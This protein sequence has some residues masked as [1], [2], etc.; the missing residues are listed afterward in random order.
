MSNLLTMG[1]NFAF[2][3][4]DVVRGTRRVTRS[5]SDLENHF[6]RNRDELDRLNRQFNSVSDQGIANIQA[7][8]VQLSTYLLN[9]NVAIDNFFEK[10]LNQLKNVEQAK[11][12]LE[13]TLGLPTATGSDLE[14]LQ[15]EFGQFNDIIQDTA[16]RTKFTEVEVTKAFQALVT[17]GYK[18]E[19]A[20]KALQPTLDFTAASQGVLTLEE[21]IN[22]VTLAVT[23]FGNGIEDSTINMDQ[24]LRTS[25]KTKIQIQDMVPMLESMGGAEMSFGEIKGLPKG[26]EL[27]VLAA[28]LKLQGQSA[29]EAGHGV[30]SFGRSIINMFK[31]VN[32]EAFRGDEAAFKRINEKRTALI[33]LM[34]GGH[35]K[36]FDKNATEIQKILNARV[37]GMFTNESGQM[38]SATEILT[39]FTDKFRELGDTKDPKNLALLQTAVGGEEGLKMIRGAIKLQD[40]MAKDGIDR[41]KALMHLARQI[42]DIQGDSAAA[43]KRDLETIGGKMKLLESATQAATKALGE[44]D[45]ATKGLLDVQIGLT[46]TIAQV[47]ANNKTLSK[48]IMGLGRVFQVATDFGY[49]FGFMLVAAA[50]F[51]I[52]ITHAMRQANI[53]TR[54]FGTTMR[55]FGSIFLKPTLLV[56]VQFVGV[57]AGASLAMAGLIHYFGEGKT[58]GESFGNVISSLRTKFEE[59]LPM[60]KLLLG[61][62]EKLKKLGG[63][64][65]IAD[66]YKNAAL[67]ARKVNDIQ[68]QLYEALTKDNTKEYNRLNKELREADNRLIA[69]KKTLGEETVKKL[70][71]VESEKSLLRMARFTDTLRNSFKNLVA[72]IDGALIPVT[73][74]IGYV[75]EGLAIALKLVFLPLMTI[76]KLFGLFSD[77]AGESGESFSRFVGILVGG[78]LGLGL[79]IK[80]I[81]F[82]ITVASG[83]FLSLRTSIQ[84]FNSRMNATRQGLTRLEQNYNVQIGIIDRLHLEYLQATGQVEKFQSAILRLNSRL[85]RTA[86]RL[87]TLNGGTRPV[88]LLRHA[89]DILGDRFPRITVGLSAMRNGMRTLAGTARSVGTALRGAFGPIMAILGVVYALAEVF[90]LSAQTLE[91]L[92]TALSLGAA[93]FALFTVGGWSALGILTLLVGKFLLVLGTIGLIIYAV[94]ALGRAFGFEWATSLANSM[95]SVTK[96]LFSSSKKVPVEA[97]VTPMGAT[98]SVTR[99]SPSMETVSGL[100]TD[101]T[102]ARSGASTVN[103]SNRFTI[104]QT[105]NGNVDPSA[106]KMA[107]ASGVQTVVRRGRIE[108]SPDAANLANARG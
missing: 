67:Q 2:D 60:L 20:I 34:L 42:A 53:A 9:A 98:S 39:I 88:S 32:K 68:S 64:E 57:I 107:S 70:I 31:T 52:G 75:F 27:L 7:G 36:L 76:A 92:S 101:T 40:K 3:A 81:G 35:V 100:S 99:V 106:V 83:K 6:R 19:E 82:V 87:G 71:P 10:T 5:M 85:A 62:D 28:A 14:R 96:S 4:A 49:K 90:G 74:S 104:N 43:A 13:V 103:N 97:S 73:L 58:V 72:F 25:Q 84:N 79:A 78:L 93:G 86:Q 51:S 45:V 1:I 80:T 24:L 89:F 41:S 22:A 50:T 65:S 26:S 48:G 105:F 33:K 77:E 69:L 16:L 38:K 63:A 12:G 44:Q 23:G 55:A 18:A 8:L 37:R 54:G 21:G 108:I 59:F 17:A 66:G 47:L 46:Q 94:A 91:Y 29:R 30:K 15:K 56:V 61:T 102:L 11:A 95:E